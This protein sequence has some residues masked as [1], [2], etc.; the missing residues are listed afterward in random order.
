MAHDQRHYDVKEAANLQLGQAG[1]DVISDT[2]VHTGIWIKILFL[3]D[4]TF[5]T[6]T[7]EN[8]GTATG[9]IYPQGKEI[10]GLFTAITLASGQ[11]H[12]TRGT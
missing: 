3:Q 12:A 9:V 10:V 7:D 8:G 6:L 11:V 1:W 4:T 5:T 2:N